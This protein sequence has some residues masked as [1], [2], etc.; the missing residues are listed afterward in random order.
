MP[1]EQEVLAFLTRVVDVAA[2][3][4][5]RVLAPPT[6]LIVDMGVACFAAGVSGAVWAALIIEEVSAER[7]SNV[8]LN[9][10]A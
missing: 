9:R 2:D 4:G 10:E 1:R 6:A 3:A 5:L 8:V 7:N